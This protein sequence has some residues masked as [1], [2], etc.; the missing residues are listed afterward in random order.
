MIWQKDDKVFIK[1]RVQP[2][3]SRER[4]EC[5]DGKLKVWVKAPPKDNKANHALVDLLSKRLGVKKS[6]IKIERGLK[7][8]NKLISVSGISEKYIRDR[9]GC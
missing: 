9:L 6:S 7:D 8:R 3:A 5:L 4:I 2:S 1:I